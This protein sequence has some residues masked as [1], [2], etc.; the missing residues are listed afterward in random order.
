M[1]KWNTITQ[2]TN[3]V[4]VLLGANWHRCIQLSSSI[5]LLKCYMLFVNSSPR[6]FQAK[7]QWLF[8]N[9]SW[10]VAEQLKRGVELCCGYV[11]VQTN[12]K[13]N[14]I[15][16]CSHHYSFM[17]TTMFR[18]VNTSNIN[19][20]WSQIISRITL[21]LWIHFVSILWVK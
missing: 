10:S 4:D 12:I 13:R 15:S 3:P 9:M 1:I 19:S 16:G 2:H 7:V 17:F 20:L 5:L 11:Y 21:N 14:N 18:F 8:R 6:A